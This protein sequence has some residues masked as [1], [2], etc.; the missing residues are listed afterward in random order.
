M[1]GLQKE[2]A[3]GWCTPVVG[4]YT[5]LNSRFGENNVRLMR[6][7]GVPQNGACRCCDSATASGHNPCTSHEERLVNVKADFPMEA[8]AQFAV[9]M[10]IDGT[11]AMHVATNDVVAAFRRVACADLSTTIVAQWDPRPKS[12]GGQRVKLFYVQ[13]FNF[14][15]KSAVMAYN[16]VAEFQTRAAVRLLPVVACH[17]FDDFCCAEPDYSCDS[18]QQSLEQFMRL[19]GLD[20]GGIVGRDKVTYSCSPRSKHRRG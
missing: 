17:Y 12:V 16:A 13:G 2:V 14:G 19:T 9:H 10:E 7:F 11:W 20:L 6:R 4:G 1:G 8:A 15:L 18:A 3:V 5:E